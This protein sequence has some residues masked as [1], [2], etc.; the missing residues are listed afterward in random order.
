RVIGVG[1]I[2]LVVTLVFGAVRIPM[3]KS[4]M[5][6]AEPARA[7][8]VQANM[9]LMA[10]REDPNEGLRRHRKLTADLRASNI[11]FVVWSESS[12]MRAVYEDVAASE[13]RGRF[14]ASL[15]VPAIFGA[16][17]VKP[18]P[19]RPKGYSLYNTAVATDIK[20][21]TTGRYNKQYLLAFGEYL[22]LGDTF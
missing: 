14:T 9:A 6:A 20:G 13:F 1:V 2:A 17:V 15:G 21:D 22:P 11:D 3:T 12:V 4:R 16:V 7:G 5:A 18:N 19:D 8:M 10:K